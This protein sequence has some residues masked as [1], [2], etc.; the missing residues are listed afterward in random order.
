MPAVD[1]APTAADAFDGCSRGCRKLGRHTRES[2]CEFAPPP[3]PPMPV[4]PVTFIAEDG[5]L[6]L[7]YD[8]ITWEQAAEMVRRAGEAIE[9]RR[10]ALAEREDQAHPEDTCHRCGGPNVTWFAPSPLW[11]EAMRGGDISAADQFDGIVCPTCF[12]VLAEAAGIAEFWRFSAERV[13]RPLKTVT[14][15]GRTWNETT[16]MWEASS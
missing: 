8:P 13:H 10:T 16:W 6:S 1:E 9:A 11:N 12:A 15:S 2:G 5:I 4:L 14:P 3:P 7:R